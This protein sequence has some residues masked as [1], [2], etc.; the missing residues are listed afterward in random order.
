M[1]RRQ[2]SCS[3]TALLIACTAGL[4]S[5]VTADAGDLAGVAEKMEAAWP[6]WLPRPEQCPAD[7]MPA[8]AGAPVFSIEQC[9][10]AVE[11]CIDHCRAGNVSDCYAAGLVLQS[12]KDSPLTDALFLRACKL[13]AA[14]GCTNRAATMEAS[15][16]YACPNRTY[17]LACARDDPWACTMMGFHLIKGLG[18]E[19]DHERARRMLAKSCRFGD[20]DEACINAKAMLKAIGN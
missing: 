5:P 7:A 12:V 18:V 17:E 15:G 8:N 19:K 11:Q 4:F 9:S 14:S 20:A 2:R 16:D 3:L 10:A 1:S 6:D 13:G